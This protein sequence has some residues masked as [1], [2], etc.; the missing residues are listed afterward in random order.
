[1]YISTY[2]VHFRFTFPS[3]LIQIS[4]VTET[5]LLLIVKRPWYILGHGRTCWK[6]VAWL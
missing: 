4:V 3:K 2:S 5:T 6:Q 1:M